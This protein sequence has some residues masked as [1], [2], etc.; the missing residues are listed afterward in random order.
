MKVVSTV[1]LA[2]LLGGC[3]AVGPDYRKPP[4][5]D[6]A[7]GWSK[8]DDP[9]FLPSTESIKNWWMLFNDPLLNEL[10]EAASKNNLDVRV[11]MASVAEARAE[12]GIINGDKAPMVGVG[13][14]AVRSDG[15]D[16]AG[17]VDTRYT[18][19]VDATWEIDLFGQIRREV[20]AATADYQA[21]EE[22]LN[23]VMITL[24]A[25][26]ARTYLT[27]RALQASL[28]AATGNIESQKQVVDL[29]EKRF[30]HGL[31]TDLDV[32]Q[33][34]RTL[35]LSEA[36][37]PPLKINL[38]EAINTISVLIGQPPGELNDRL[39]KVQPVPLPEGPVTVGVPSNLLRQRPDI[40]K[41][42]RQLAAQVARI[43]VAKGELYPKLSLN[44]SFNYSAANAGSLFSGGNSAFSFG[45]SLRWNIF[46]GGKIKNLIK[47]E[48]ARTLQALFI[49]ERTVLNA[50]NE[51]ENSMTAYLEQQ[52]Q[53]EAQKRAQA[54]ARRSFD[55]STSLY[56]QGLSDFQNVLDAQTALFDTENQVAAARGQTAVN[57]VAIYKAIGGGWDPE[58][59]FKSD[60]NLEEAAEKFITPLTEESKNEK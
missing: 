20:E 31:S 27:I 36:K 37:V 22:Q 48:D 19:G 59:P 42:E 33:A 15:L 53:F 3:A 17:S 2:L 51:V 16:P 29:T 12:L 21:T 23:D 1:S 34:K 35:A 60:M 9:A 8:A 49:Y 32:S 57:L 4:K 30:K 26:I 54:S 6:T 50:L 38:S 41:A 5:I 55:L 28:V 44:G 24:Y 52:V 10:I 11:A 40:R 46:Q 56:K 18:T 47:A 58:V 43:G 7:P 39:D 45:P 25:E 14:E 13:G